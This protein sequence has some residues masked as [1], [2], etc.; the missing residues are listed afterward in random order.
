MCDDVAA[1]RTILCQS[2]AIWSRIR[3]ISSSGTTTN[4]SDKSKPGQFVGLIYKLTKFVIRACRPTNEQPTQNGDKLTSRSANRR[5]KQR[6]AQI[7]YPL[8]TPK[9]QQSA[10][11]PPPVD[12]SRRHWT[13]TTKGRTTLHARSRSTVTTRRPTICK[14]DTASRYTPT[15]TEYEQ[16][17]SRRQ[18]TGARKQKSRII[19]SD[20]LV[21]DTGIEP[22]T[23]SV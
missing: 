22:V 5:V 14:H 9:A 11:S 16:K 1:Y 15:P 6:P 2:P 4:T 23:S 17:S 8:I 7:E 18:S 12:A 19:R 3:T 20:L 10:T 13:L 21:G